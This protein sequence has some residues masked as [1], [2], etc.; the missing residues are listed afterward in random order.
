MIN[1]LGKIPKKVVVACSGGPDSM[2]AASFLLNSRREIS[3]L[4]FDHGTDHSKD[5]RAL[6]EKFCVD[7]KVPLQIV[8][9]KGRP[10]KGES[11]EKWWRDKRYNAFHKYHLPIIT[12]HN[13]NDVAEWWM[14]TSLRGNPRIMPYQNKNVIRPFLLTKKIDLEKWCERNSVPFTIDPTNLGDRFS[15]SLI[16]KNIIPEALRVAPGFLTTMS[17]KV[18]EIYTES[19]NEI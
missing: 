9:I 14:F 18:R 17:N 7:R 5:A 16:R 10:P 1:I 4:H 3:I 6:V 13:L 19:Q 11:C 8:D 12:A 2:A 15:R